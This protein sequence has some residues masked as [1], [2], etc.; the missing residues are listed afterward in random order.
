MFLAIPDRS[1]PKS[2]EA[3]AKWQEEQE[4]E[5]AGLEPYDAGGR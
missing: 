2:A 5:K 3:A 1:A 4:L